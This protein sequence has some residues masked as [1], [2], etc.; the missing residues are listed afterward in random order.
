M[1]TDMIVKELPRICTS[2]LEKPLLLIDNTEYH[3]RDCV[4]KNLVATSYF[5]TG[6]SVRAVDDAAFARD[7]LARII[8]SASTYKAFVGTEKESD[9]KWPL[10]D[11][12]M[13]VAAR[14]EKS[15][16]V[17]NATTNYFR[18]A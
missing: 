13:I 7:G 1:T 11:N 4:I 15:G 12:P 10:D 6:Q 3:R 17:V 16:Q 8:G 9:V 18:A 5:Y 2:V 14:Y